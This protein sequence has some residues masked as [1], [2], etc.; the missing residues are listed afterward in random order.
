MTNQAKNSGDINIIWER[1]SLSWTIAALC[2]LLG[3]WGC[4]AIYSTQIVA[5]NDWG[6]LGRQIIFLVIGLPIMVGCWKIPFSYN[7]KFGWILGILA[8]AA[9]SLFRL[10]NY[11]H[12]GMV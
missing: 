12:G 4:L 5:L 6:F 2:A 11:R 10:E 3:L 8:L 9:G 1:S 7:Q